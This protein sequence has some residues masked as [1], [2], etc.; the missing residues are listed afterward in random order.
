MKRG[1]Y[2]AALYHYSLSGD[3]KS[4]VHAADYVV[5]LYFSN[6]PDPSLQHPD[7]ILEVLKS[8]LLD[9]LSEFSFF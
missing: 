9:F 1:K 8:S 3:Q 6:Y 4:L 2:S 7:V 5:S